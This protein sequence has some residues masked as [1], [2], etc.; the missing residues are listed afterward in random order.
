MMEIFSTHALLWVCPALL[1]DQ[2][3]GEPQ[4]FHP[5]VGFGKWVRWVEGWSYGSASM[6]PGMRKAHGIGALLIVLFP[7][8]LLSLWINTLALWSEAFQLLALYWAVGSRSLIEHGRAVAEA[9]NHKSLEDARQKVSLLVSRETTEMDEAAIARATIESILENGCDAIFA[10]LFWFML[11][12]APGV[13]LYRLANTLDAMWGYK[14]TRY[15]AFGWSAARLDDILNYIPARL[16]AITY[17]LLGDSHQAWQAWRYCPTRKSPNA[18]LVMAVGA[19]ALHLQLGGA[20]TY[21]GQHQHNP[22]LGIGQPASCKDI[23]RALTLLRRGMMVW[24]MLA[25]ISG[26]WIIA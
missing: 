25:L 5:L 18:T 8:L 6:T 20:V 21:F 13:I 3:L 19:G 7:L 15:H 22:L 23:G 17:L 1:L 10:A 24:G 12:G 4:H 9:I 26:V 14:N 11:L 16:S 2:L